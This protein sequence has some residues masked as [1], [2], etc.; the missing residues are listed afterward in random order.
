[1]REE[2]TNG[3]VFMMFAYIWSE[4]GK[5]LESKKWGRLA[6]CY[7]MWSTDK[8]ITFHLCRLECYTINNVKHS[9]FVSRLVH[10]GSIQYQEKLI[11]TDS[12]HGNCDTMIPRFSSYQVSC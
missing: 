6:M 1:M 2:L 3:S 12:P 11:E 7:D 10:F 5:T 8:N 9:W 4:R